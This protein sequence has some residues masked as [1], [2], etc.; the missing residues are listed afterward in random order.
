MKA[1]G[2]FCRSPSLECLTQFFIRLCVGVCYVILCYFLPFSYFFCNYCL[3]FLSF[4]IS[5]AVHSFYTF[6]SFSTVDFKKSK[7]NEILNFPSLNLCIVTF[8]KNEKCK[9]V[10]NMLY[11]Y[12]DRYL[13][14]YLLFAYIHN[15]K[16]SY[17][18][19]MTHSVLQ[20][21]SSKISAIHDIIKT[22]CPL[23]YHY[24]GFRL[25]SPLGL[26]TV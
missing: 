16:T 24:H 21:H 25:T 8:K 15:Y 7:Y 23:R 1:T 6:G 17:T 22:T 2:Y 19:S 10:I 18:W 9:V 14:W 13:C 3:S 26:L 4:L 11:I 12:D 5:P 20:S